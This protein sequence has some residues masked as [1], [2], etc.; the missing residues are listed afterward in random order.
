M[1]VRAVEVVPYALRFAEPYVSA[2]GAL[3]RREMALIRIATDEGV[4]GLGEAVPLT[5]R[6]GAALGAVVTELREAGAALVGADLD[7]ADPG[8]PPGRL[9][10]RLSAPAAA[11][12]EIARLDLAA[13]LVGVPLWRLL[14][15]GR[16]APVRCNATLSAGA[17]ARVAAAAERWAELGFASFKLKVGAGDDVGQVAAV[18]STLGRA[19]RI[20]IDANGAWSAQAASARLGAI[21]AEG[22]ELAE[23]PAATLEELAEV[24]ARTTIPIAADESVA[25][26][27]DASRAAELGGCDLATIKLAKVGG[28]GAARRIAAIVPSY[29]SSAL[30]GPVGIAAAAHLAQVLP[31]SE[32]TDGLAHGLATQLLFADTVAAS[33]CEV[34]AGL[35]H[36]PDGPGLGVE[37]D[38]A[39]LERARI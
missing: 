14:G 30:D 10:V 4:E 15:A 31:A 16:Q 32:A 22:I 28:I 12:L 27:A 13:K 8:P 21:E 29:L 37:L 34:R 1:R 9:G 20:R 17:P 7:Q 23:Q 24:R 36:P 26:A 25:S 33:Q 3:E 6:G 35:L 38:P 2:R 19:A 18:R 11:A 5:L 39:A